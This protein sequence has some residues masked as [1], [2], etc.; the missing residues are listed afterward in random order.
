MNRIICLLL[1]IFLSI[2]SNAN[3]LLGKWS[4]SKNGYYLVV[5]FQESSMTQA[6]S[7]DLK[8][9]A[10]TIDVKY[11]K[12]KDSSGI[13]LLDENGK[14]VAAMMATFLNSNTIKFGQPG[15]VFFELKREE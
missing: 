15:S 6:T 13:E 1:L 5:L 10:K 12:L 4:T 7:L 2:N 9:N 3:E 14:Q 11:V 8:D